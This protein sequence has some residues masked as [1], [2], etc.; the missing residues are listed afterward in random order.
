MVVSSANSRGSPADLPHAAHDGHDLVA[1]VPVQSP[2]PRGRSRCPAAPG[3]APG[4]AAVIGVAGDQHMR[5]RRLG[6]HPA[7]DQAGRRRRLHD[8]P[9]RRGTPASAASSRRR[10]TARGSRRAARPHRRRSRP[11]GPGSRGRP[12]P[13]APAP[14]RR[15]ADA[16]AAGRAPRGG[17]S[18]GCPAGRQ[19]PCR[20]PPRSRP[21]SPRS[22]R[23]RTAA[24]PPQP[25]RLLPEL[26][27]LELQQQM[28]EALILARQRITLGHQRV[29]QR[30]RLEQ[31]RAQCRGILRQGR[32]VVIRGAH[33]AA[34]LRRRARC[35]NLPQRLH[36]TPVDTVEQR[37]NSTASGAARRP[38]A[39]PAECAALQ[40]LPISTRPLP[41]QSRILTRSARRERNTS[42]AP[43]K[44][45]APSTS[46]ASPPGCAR[47]CGSRRAS[48]PGG[49]AR[50]A[51]ARSCRRGPDRAQHRRQELAVRAGCDAQ[52]RARS[53]TSIAA[54]AR[55]GAA[56]GSATTGAVSPP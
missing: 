18:P 32:R 52:H 23:T 49:F 2:A 14:P 24:A 21:A 45:S 43:E 7:L 33:R 44:G 51:A 11:A 5:D 3:S 8:T 53:L 26:P 27:A 4:T 50:T 25:L 56:T 48:S 38:P 54:V 55:A 6:R 22:P 41:S 10:G 40:L 31:Q 29:D 35:G 42:T 12:S 47:P 36:A 16:P 37:A 30:P 1:A 34:I 13:R 39:A 20:P 46:A 19:T 15:A 9:G 17:A 28:L